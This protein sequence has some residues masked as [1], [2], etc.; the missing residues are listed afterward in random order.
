MNKEK[1]EK[2]KEINAIMLEAG[3]LGFAL[4]KISKLVKEIIDVDRISIFIYKK[5]VELLYTYK[6]DFIEKL[7]IPASKG[8][9]GYVAK[10]KV[11]K[12][13]NDTSKEPLFFKGVDKESGYHTHNILALPILNLEEEVLG[14]VEFINK[15]DGDFND[16]DIA[17]AKLFVK[18]IAEPLET[19]LEREKN[20]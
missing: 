15:L 20:V 7:I 13:V 5:K 1:L 2:L 4:D 18:Y 19:I 9:V 11:I 6:A 16:K 8:I 12:I 17:I 14:V 3:S 10:H